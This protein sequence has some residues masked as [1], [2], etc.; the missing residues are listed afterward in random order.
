MTMNVSRFFDYA[1]PSGE[2]HGELVFLPDLPDEGWRKLLSYT[3]TVRYPAGSMV[4]REGETDRAL[5]VVTEGTLEVLTPDPRGRA[6][7]RVAMIDTGSVLGE[8][9]F[10]DGRPRSASIH[11]VTDSELLRL[12]LERFEVLAAR[13]PALARAVLFDLGRI[14]AARLR[15]TSEMMAHAVG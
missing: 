13:E 8:M 3:N 2:R 1:D 15:Q 5:Y 10:F 4:I 9:S 14:L 12:S 7:R 6:P 11:A